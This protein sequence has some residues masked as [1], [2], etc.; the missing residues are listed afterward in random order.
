MPGVFPAVDFEGALAGLGVGVEE[1]AEGLLEAVPKGDGTVFLVLTCL[2]YQLVGT[3]VNF[4]KTAGHLDVLHLESTF[5][6][7][8]GRASVGREFA[9]AAPVAEGYVNGHQ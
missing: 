6:H 8:C 7:Y 9:A 1:D 5:S 4:G 2:F 3:A